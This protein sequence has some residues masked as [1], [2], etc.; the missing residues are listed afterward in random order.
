MSREVDVA[1]IGAGSAGLYALGQVRHHTNNYVLIDGGPLG[2]TCARVGCMPSKAMIQV[3]DDY[4]HRHQFEREGISG[5]A[6][7]HVRSAS[8]LEHVRLMRDTFVGRVL[9]NSTGKMS[10][11]H[12]IASNAHFVD[13]H[14]LETDDGQRIHAHR[15]IVATGSR[16][17]VPGA[18]AE[19]SDHLF[20]TDEI[21]E[22]PKL[23][24][25]VAVIGLGVIGLELGQAM[26]R[27]GVQVTGIDQQTVI[28]GIA[29]PVVNAAA[30][31]IIGDEFPLWLGHAADLAW[32]ED[33]RVRVTAGERAVEVDAVLVSL[34]RRPNFDGLGMEAAG[35]ALDERGMPDFDPETLRVRDNDIFIAGDCSNLR[36]VLH[37]AAFEGRVAGFNATRGESMAFRRQTPL[38]I[39][40]CDPNIV[41][42]GARLDELDAKDI[43][44]GEQELKPSGRAMVMG[45]NAG[46]VRVY[47]ARTDGRLLGAAMAAVKGEDLAHLVAWSIE[48]RFTVPQL[49]AMPFYHPTLEEALQGALYNAKSKLDLDWPEWPFELKPA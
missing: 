37:E 1:I 42:V 48:A 46:V 8:A 6:S 30:V 49:L 16:P 40:F 3:A 26:S 15:I 44:I 20:T 43:V 13:A 28:G 34:G 5:M 21:F 11:E 22:L 9:A 19:F 35:V 27:L 4:H 23:P 29:D 47:A 24:E 41:S 25:S 14:T 33:G 38:G 39:T 36:P 10:E 17:V 18:W 31:D 32:A 12:F 45:R 7:M 2:T